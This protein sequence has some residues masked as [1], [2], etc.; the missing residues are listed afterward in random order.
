MPASDFPPKVSL[1]GGRCHGRHGFV[2]GVSR[3]A[4]PFAF[5]GLWEP[6]PIVAQDT[7]T[8]LTCE[9]NEL[10]AEVHDRMPVIL[11]PDDW[12]RWLSTPE[13]RAKLLKPFPAAQMEMWPVTTAVGSPKNTGPE[14]VDPI[15]VGR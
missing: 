15:S 8:I 11:A 6:K 1:R 4:R 13:E 3:R 12:E 5:A 7:F 2:A 14:L 10:C 9:P